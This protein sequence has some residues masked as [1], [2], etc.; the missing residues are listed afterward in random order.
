MTA[1]GRTIRLSYRDALRELADVQ[2]PGA[3]VPAYTRWVN[4]NLGRG[5]AA[6]V[7]VLGLSPNT[8]TTVSALISG[9]GLFVLILAPVNPAT[10]LLVS[11]LLALGYVFDS[12]D[13]QVARLSGR[14]SPAGE[15]L[16]HVVDA[17]RTPAMHLAVF[18]ALSRHNDA[19][20]PLQWIALAYALVS[21]GL[22]MSQILAEQLA[23][24]SGIP[25]VEEDGYKKSL[26]LLPTDAGMTCW[27]F[28]VWGF[29][30]L[31]TGVYIA[32]FVANTL[33]TA[34]SMRRKYTKLGRA[35]TW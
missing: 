3:G 5:V 28:I 29:S 1:P 33:H 23:R 35:D 6:A 20:V 12:A 16:D 8:V 13:G 25:R 9:I 11:V 21:V 14:S 32:M 34:A 17:V 31:F 4:R 26:I 2:K 18:I 19:I 24:R 7:H 10:G 22:F 27:M 15:W 30:P